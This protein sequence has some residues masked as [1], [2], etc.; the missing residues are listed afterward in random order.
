LMWVWPRWWRG[1]AGVP[2]SGARR[3]AIGVAAFGPVALLGLPGLEMDGRS[4]YFPW[5]GNTFVAEPYLLA[6]SSQPPGEPRTVLP[7]PVFKIFSVAVLGLLGGT[8]VH[9]LWRRPGRWLA[10]SRAWLASQPAVVVVLVAFAAV[11]LPLLLFKSFVPHSHGIWDRYLLPLLPLATLGV[12]GACQRLGRRRMPAGAWVALVL[13]AAYGTAHMHDYFALLRARTAV[14]QH[15]ER[16]GIERG[17]IL[18]GFEYDGWTQISVAGYYNDP[19]IVH[20]AGVHQPLAPDPGF[21]TL[22][23]MWRRHTPVITPDYVVAVSRHPDL[24]DT[25]IAPR[26]YQCWLPPFRGRIVVQVRDPKLART[27]PL[28]GPVERGRVE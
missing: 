14:T 27:G 6:S 8:L 1:P 12:L 11:Y 5:M 23:Q 15:L 26:D 20:P 10:G 19:R 4:W 17:R 13:F 28:P 18:G 22:Y 9:I 24:H 3:L 16:L 25:D 21:R 2:A 7:L